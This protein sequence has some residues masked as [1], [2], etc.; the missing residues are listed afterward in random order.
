MSTLDQWV[1][2]KLKFDSDI[3]RQ[4]AAEFEELMFTDG[5]VLGGRSAISSTNFA[6]RDTPCSTG[7]A[8]AAGCSS[9]GSFIPNFIVEGAGVTLDEIGLFGFPPAEAGGENPTLGGGDLAVMLSDNE[10]TRRSWS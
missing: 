6:P 3:V 7:R 2:D 4:A 1:T 9:R 10:D 5:N 8:G